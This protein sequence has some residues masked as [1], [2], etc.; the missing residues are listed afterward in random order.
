MW[1]KLNKM[2]VQH[3]AAILIITG[4]MVLAFLSWIK[5][6]TQGAKEIIRSYYDLALF[7]SCAFLFSASK[8][9]QQS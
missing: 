3:I 8:A 7:S 6:P 5:E 2:Q 9:K 4:A 1:E